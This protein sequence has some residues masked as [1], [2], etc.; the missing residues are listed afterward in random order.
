MHPS[1][2]APQRP[3]LRRETLRRTFDGRPY[4]EGKQAESSRASR[5]IGG[6]LLMEDPTDNKAPTEKEKPSF[7]L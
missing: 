6:E 7:I 2:V 5:D 3:L 4:G 1:S